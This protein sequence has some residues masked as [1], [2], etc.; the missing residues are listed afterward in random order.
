MSRPPA[1]FN[2]AD[3]KPQVAAFVGVVNWIERFSVGHI[4]NPGLC[5]AFKD[6]GTSPKGES[7]DL[8]TILQAAL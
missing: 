4:Q 6:R 7:T 5:R 3:G 8:H 2:Y 1:T